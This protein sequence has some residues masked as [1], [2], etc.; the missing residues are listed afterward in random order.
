MQFSPPEV[1]AGSRRVASEDDTDQ[2]IMNADWTTV[3]V[4]TSRSMRAENIRIVA[5][6]F[7]AVLSSAFVLAGIAVFVSCRRQ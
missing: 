2:A 7:F 6:I 5:L 4:A 3:T 1:A